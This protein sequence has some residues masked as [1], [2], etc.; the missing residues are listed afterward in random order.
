MT[1]EAMQT[2]E[3]VTIHYAPT[4]YR[5]LGAVELVGKRVEGDRIFDLRCLSGD[6]L[7]PLVSANRKLFGID[8]FAPAVLECRKVLAE[9]GCPDAV[10]L[11]WNLQQLPELVRTETFDSIVCVDILNHVPDDGATLKQIHDILSPEGKLL[12]VVPAHPWLEGARDRSL[13]HLRR[14]S[15]AGIEGLLKASGFEVMYC[16]AWNFLAFFPYLFVEKLLKIRLH[17]SVRYAGAEAK[18]P[19]LGPMLRW[20]YAH[21]EVYPLF[22]VGLSFFVEARRA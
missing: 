6:L 12:L 20:W 7:A 18:S 5:R 2:H 8:G 9:K 16:R 19:L 4:D 21:V 14:Y 15:K 13:G 3:S 10:V 1:Y 22:P 17:D 11:H